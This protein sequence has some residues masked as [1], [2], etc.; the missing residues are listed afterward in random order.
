MVIIKLKQPKSKLFITDL[1][2]NEEVGMADGPQKV[3]SQVIHNGYLLTI[4]VPNQAGS[5]RPAS[6]HRS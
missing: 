5:R 6:T 4:V 2:D 1:D 3:R